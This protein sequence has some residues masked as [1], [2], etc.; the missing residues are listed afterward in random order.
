MNLYLDLDCLVKLC[1]CNAIQETL[2]LFE[3]QPQ[4][5]F[6]ID[7]FLY[8]AQ[9][10]HKK[11]QA[12]EAAKAEVYRRVCEE[13]IPKFQQI[14]PDKDAILYVQKMSC[15]VPEIDQ[16]E[17]LLMYYA[18]QDTNAVFFATGDKKCL[19]SL[20][21]NYE[22]IPKLFYALRKKIIHLE[23]IIYILLYQE[24][25]D[26][27]MSKFKKFVEIKLDKAL[28]IIMHPNN[29]DEILKALKSYRKDFYSEEWLVE[30]DYFLGV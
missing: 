26:E 11:L 29:K 23:D 12:K 21:D 7:S 9:K 16:G 13:E 24:E 17:A 22:E 25:K 14:K 10:K 1:S 5:V 28:S 20:R 6:I 3:I 8:C 15:N 18:S 19:R 4:S 30:L 27:L 2:N